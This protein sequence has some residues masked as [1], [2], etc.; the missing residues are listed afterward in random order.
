MKL[1]K[2]LALAFLLWVSLLVCAQNPVSFTSDQGLSN[3]C[4]RSMKQ[5]SRKNVWICTQYGLNRFDG[6]KMNV[7]HYKS[8]EKGSLGHDNTTCVL[9]QEPGKILVGLEIGVQS[10][11]YDTDEFTDIPLISWKGDTIKAHVVSMTKLSDG[12]VYVCTAGYGLFVLKEE[13]GFE[14][15]LE[16]NT[17]PQS[18]PP[19][20]IMEDR[21]KRIWALYP[22]GM[23]YCRIK[24]K[25][26]PVGT[27]KF[28]SRLCESSSG[29][30]YLASVYGGLRVY[31][32][33]DRQFHEV[34]ETSKQYVIASVTATPNGTLLISTDGNGLKVYDE[35][36]GKIEQS[37]IRTYE[38]NLATSNVKDAMMDAD[39]NVWVGV[40]WKGV[41]VMPN[42]ATSFEY[43]GRRSVHKNTL[44]TNCVTA[45]TGDG[46]GALW[47][48]T[49]HCGVYH[50]A[51]DGTSSVH[52]KPELV[53][54]MPSTVMRRENKECLY[55]GRG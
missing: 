5:D 24:G 35:K 12:T 11:S 4:I 47:V 17:F 50:L 51:A 18:V 8:D 19:L 26:H 23:V 32:E 41:W 15:L 13:K 29:R 30:I 31:S 22:S 45:I 34:D 25:F 49:D 53:S 40:Y 28:G 1:N 54:G 36:T 33:A 48:A 16:I 10:Y 20:Q 3:T 52:F 6:A 7:Y 37:N 44:G 9:E 43:I 55:H 14:K 27:Y 46:K 42:T 2:F 39:G 21:Q 38:Y